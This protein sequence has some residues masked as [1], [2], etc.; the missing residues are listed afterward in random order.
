MEY[1]VY[2]IAY[3][4]NSSVEEYLEE[5]IMN[6]PNPPREPMYCALME[7]LESDNIKEELKKCL[8]KGFGTEEKK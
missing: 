2:V 8:E 7:G 3:P 4:H 1:D 5:K 6:I